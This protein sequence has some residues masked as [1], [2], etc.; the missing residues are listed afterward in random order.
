MD[1]RVV[2]GIIWIIF[3]LFMIGSGVY[4]IL[5]GAQESGIFYIIIGALILLFQF[6]LYKKTGKVGGIL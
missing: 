5:R 1:H 4:D 2:S 6:Y 3:A